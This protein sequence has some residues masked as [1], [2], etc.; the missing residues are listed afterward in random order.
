[1][2]RS[3]SGSSTAAWHFFMRFVAPVAVGA[4]LAAVILFGVDFT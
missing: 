1:M 2:A 3:R 4:I